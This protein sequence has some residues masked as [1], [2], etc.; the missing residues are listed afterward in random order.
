MDYLKD[1]RERQKKFLEKPRESIENLITQEKKFSKGVIE[2][3]IAQNRPDL[4]LIYKEFSKQ[5][6]NL[7]GKM[8]K[9]G[10]ISAMSFKD[11]LRD[12]SILQTINEMKKS[13]LNYQEKLVPLEE[14]MLSL[15][16]SYASLLE[17]LWSKLKRIIFFAGLNPM[18]KHLNL[19]GV[20]SKLNEL[21]KKY[22]VDLS[23]L[24]NI[25]KGKLRNCVHHEKTYFENP[26]FLVFVNEINGKFEE[27]YRI[28]DKDLIEEILKSFVILTTLHHIEILVII[29]HLE[30]L[31]K[32]DDKQLVEYSKTGILTEEMEKSILRSL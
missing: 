28:N 23:L 7:I 20:E 14:S 16:K 17:I 9:E 4:I 27:F 13:V 5:Y 18:E 6:S 15:K 30:S 25:L 19:N 11:D 22:S 12:V 10:L 31:L 2:L 8:L 29:S 1:M 24:K 26:N 3:G 21:E 32:L